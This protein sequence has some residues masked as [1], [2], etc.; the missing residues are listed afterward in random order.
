MFAFLTCTDSWDESDS[1][2][3]LNGA[4]KPLNNDW[5][6]PND[7]PSTPPGLPSTPQS[8]W[9][10]YSDTNATQNSWVFRI[11]V[12]RPL[13]EPA[14]VKPMVPE[15]VHSVQYGI[16][17]ERLLLPHSDTEILSHI[18]DDISSIRDSNKASVMSAATITRKRHMACKGVAVPAFRKANERNPSHQPK[19]RFDT[20]VPNRL[21]EQTRI[22]ILNWNP[23]Y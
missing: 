12:L 4:P 8:S 17:P 13:D 1:P 20:S 9:Q 16:T 21:L 19:Y 3:E 6:I 5:S 7:L 15:I 22:S 14:A 18:D 23:S 11:R 2:R 10:P